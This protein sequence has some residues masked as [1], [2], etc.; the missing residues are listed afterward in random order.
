[1]AVG[2]WSAIQSGQK[3][4]FFCHWYAFAS[5]GWGVLFSST[6]CQ[7]HSITSAAWSSTLMCLGSSSDNSKERLTRGFTWGFNSEK[8]GSL[9]YSISSENLDEKNL[10]K[11][12]FLFPAIVQWK[13]WQGNWKVLCKKM[14]QHVLLQP[15]LDHGACGIQVTEI[16]VMD[17]ITLLSNRVFFFVIIFHFNGDCGQICG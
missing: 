16:S 1:M 14:H 15:A 12:Q 10:E 11:T 2:N 8:K 6:E 5:A 13:I 3:L 4:G 17:W 7:W 9:K